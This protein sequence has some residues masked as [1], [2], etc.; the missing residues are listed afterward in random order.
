MVDKIDKSIDTA[1]TCKAIEYAEISFICIVEL[2]KLT[3]CKNRDLIAEFGADI[4]P[5][6]VGGN[7][8]IEDDW[9]TQLDMWKEEEEN[10]AKRLA[11]KG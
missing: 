10:V 2:G 5:V 7:L 1:K 8:E 9:P 11:L 6:D 4:L 3:V